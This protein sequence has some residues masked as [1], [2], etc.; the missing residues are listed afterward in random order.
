M[1]VFRYHAGFKNP[2]ACVITWGNMDGVHLGHQ[3]LIRKNTDLAG[4]KNLKSMV[5][6]FEPITV[7]C[8]VKPNITMLSDLT[9]RLEKIKRLGVDIVL[10]VPF[11]RF[12]YERDAAWF[13]HEFLMK[14][15]CAH[16]IVIGSDA[17]FGKGRSG[18]IS[19]LRENFYPENQAVHIP[20]ALLADNG[21][22]ISSYL[23]RQAWKNLA[24][25]DVKA[26]LGTSLM[27]RCRFYY[28]QQ[29]GQLTAIL[30]KKWHNTFLLGFYVVT[31]VQH[32]VSLLAEI[33]IESTGEGVKL[34]KLHLN[35]VLL[36]GV[37]GIQGQYFCGKNANSLED[38]VEK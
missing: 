36:P 28:D 27:L 31:I 26:M 38:F 37:Y 11:K 13:V 12:F 4:Q 20:P 17:V 10:V 34:I 3:Y 22:R 8:F 24:F 35:E 16:H 23:I 14:A 29:K 30:P 32:H 1:Q 33:S 2:S 7:K 5:V 21:V 25:T 15:C 18:D 6:I 9:G 19:F